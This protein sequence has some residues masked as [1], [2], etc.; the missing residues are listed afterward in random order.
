MSE[1]ISLARQA[2]SER[3][4]QELDKMLKDVDAHGEF[5]AYKAA[6]GFYVGYVKY[7]NDAD[8]KAEKMT[9][10]DV[11]EQMF[12]KRPNDDLLLAF[13]EL[14]E[15]CVGELK[16]ALQSVNSELAEEI[17]SGMVFTLLKQKSRDE[18][19]YW[20]LTAC[21]YHVIPLL[22]FL[23]LDK[24]SDIYAEYQRNN[25][26]NQSLPN[27]EKVRKA[28]EEQILQKGGV[29]PKTKFW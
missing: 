14:T 11:V 23:P 6:A 18:R 9:P 19:T 8:E 27:Q 25:P 5:G 24:L 15:A 16:S 26:K 21:E 7:L 17:A 13:Y 28:L 29:I 10:R 1:K 3:N 4:W 22:E 12:V 20:Q 2:F